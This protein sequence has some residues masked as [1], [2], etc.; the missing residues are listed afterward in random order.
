MRFKPFDISLRIPPVEL[1][2]A[3]HALTTSVSA[4]ARS[5]QEKHA[6][7]ATALHCIAPHFAGLCV[8]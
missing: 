2:L 1:T 4:S 6:F 3:L 8:L 7:L 5:N